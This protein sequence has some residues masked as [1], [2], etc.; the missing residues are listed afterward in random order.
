MS[1]TNI[2]MPTTERLA[3]AL[4]IF[5]Q[6]SRSYE[7][8]TTARRDKDDVIAPVRD[9]IAQ[10]VEAEIDERTGKPRY[11]SEDKRRAETERRLR[12]DYGDML[13][14]FAELEQRER[15]TKAALDRAYEELHTLRALLR[16]ET[17]V[18]EHRTAE[19]LAR[20]EVAV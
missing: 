19:L 5:H 7:Q 1:F 8:I 17:A 9:S 15:E 20:H 13:V 14:M 18:L 12:V 16:H 4:I 10:A 3:A 2:T 6:A 11:S